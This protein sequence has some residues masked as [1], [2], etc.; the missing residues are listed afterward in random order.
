MIFLTPASDGRCRSKICGLRTAAD[1]LACAAGGADAI[2]LNFWP[3]SKRYTEPSVAAKWVREIPGSLV[4]IGVFV[5]ESLDGIR[6]LLDDGL[7][8]AAQLHGDEPP[9]ACEALRREGHCVLK[10]IGVR[11]RASLD[12]ISRYPVDGIVLDAFCPGEYGGSGR[13]FDWDLA[14]QAKEILSET[15]LILSGGLHPGNVA[16]AIQRARPLAVDVAS[17]VESAPGVKSLTKVAAFLQA[18]ASA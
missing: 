3:R 17:G 6:R 18:V 4:R 11:D 12:S 16:E 10:A 2:G 1:A 7:I 15:P 9:E 14:L 5:N 13:V 8:H